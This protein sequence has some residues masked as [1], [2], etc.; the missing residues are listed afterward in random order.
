MPGLYTITTRSNGTTLTAAIYNADHQNHVDNQT[1]QMTDDYSSNVSQMQTATD[2]GE[3]GSESLATSLAGE[4]ER[5]RFAVQDIKTSLGLTS[6]Q[7]Y[8]TPTGGGVVPTGVMSEYVGSSAPT[9]W[10]LA[11]GKTIGDATS[12]AT[13]RGNPATP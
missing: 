12:G 6:A 5:L 10:V 2:P 9:G 3:V 1:P 8:S 13:E 7:W 4:I 11:D